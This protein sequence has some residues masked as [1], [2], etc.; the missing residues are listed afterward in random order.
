MFVENITHFPLFLGNT[1]IKEDQ[2]KRKVEEEAIENK[3][4]ELR[5]L[6]SRKI[7]RLIEE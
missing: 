3:K 7:D 1:W 2:I 6:I 5:D 4:K